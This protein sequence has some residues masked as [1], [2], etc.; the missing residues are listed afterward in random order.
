MKLRYLAFSALSSALCLV[1]CGSDDTGTAAPP[2]AAGSGGAAN[3]KGGTSAKGGAS[4]KGGGAGAPGKGGAA[5]KGGTPGK[6]GSPAMGGAGG[7][8]AEGGGAG[9]GGAS[10]KG[11]SGGTGGAAGKG[12][13]GGKAGGAGTGAGAA[14]ATA[15]GA[16]G[17]NTGGSDAAGSNAGGSD[18]GGS[19]AGGSTAGGSTAGGANAG[20]ST[21]GGANAGGSDAGGSAGNAAGGNA[22]A[23]TS[24]GGGSAG[25]AGSGGSPSCTEITVTGVKG[26]LYPPRIGISFQNFG[27][28]ERDAGT[29]F[30]D[31]KPA[32]GTY[33]LGVGVNAD[34]NTSKQAVFAFEDITADDAKVRYS[35]TSGTLTVASAQSAVQIKGEIVDVTLREAVVDAAGVISLVSG[36]RCLHLQSAAYDTLEFCGNNEDCAKGQGCDPA[37]LTC[38]KSCGGGNSCGNG[39]ACIAQDDPPTTGA[40]YATCVGVKGATCGGSFTCSSI[41]LAGDG[42]CRPA[43]TV[44]EGEVCAGQF[45]TATDCAPG[46]LCTLETGNKRLCRNTCVALTPS[47]GCPGAQVCTLNG[48]CTDRL[49]LVD[50]AGLNTQC[51]SQVENRF[52]GLSNGGTRG[53]CRSSPTGVVCRGLVV[54]PAPCPSGYK[55]DK[56]DPGALGGPAVSACI[57]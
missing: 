22:S 26:G 48:L 3:G 29:L 53:I 20:G 36:G 55:T 37:T 12:G 33:T 17:A 24:A 10:G 34:P 31:E 25:T 50:A 32:P 8:P 14:G 30:F 18:A 13:A 2:A 43:G 23:G 54:D 27:G 39:L 57:P 44:K 11:G 56:V 41:S 16:A 35:S 4:G 9:K 45:D 42:Y 28:P 51:V 47:P 19:S 21:A 6:G 1:A 52:C 46:L 49:D 38:V 5:G 40:C 15:A 7:E